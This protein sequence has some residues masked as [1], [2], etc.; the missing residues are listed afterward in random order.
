[1]TTHLKFS[2]YALALIATMLVPPLLCQSVWPLVPWDTWEELSEEVYA[3]LLRWQGLAKL[4]PSRIAVIEIDQRTTEALGWPLDRQH[5]VTALAKLKASGRPWVL[6][7]LRLQALSP[8]TLE[9]RLKVA[10]ATADHALAMAIKDYGRYIG[11]GLVIKPGSELEAKQEE[12]LMP[13]ITL[14]K[15]GTAPTDLPRLPLQL[16]EDA[17]L[18][19]GQ[20]TFGYGTHFGLE[21]MVLCI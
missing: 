19:E 10:R 14:A 2:W 15:S 20:A 17:R 16:A 5:Y 18:V 3:G 12:L 13:R 6:S 8:G 21:P 1:M 7:L 11:T 4:S 9:P